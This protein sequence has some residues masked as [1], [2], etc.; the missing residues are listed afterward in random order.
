MGQTPTTL[1][2]IIVKQGGRLHTPP[3]IDTEL[4]FKSSFYQKLMVC[5]IADEDIGRNRLTLRS[6]GSGRC[7]LQKHLSTPYSQGVEK[8]SQMGKVLELSTLISLYGYVHL[9][10]LMEGS[11]QMLP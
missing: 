11:V 6:K 7:V 4:Q 1:T 9:P 3:W 2:E 8:G 5:D 10:C